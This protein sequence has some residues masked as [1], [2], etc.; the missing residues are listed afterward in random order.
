[1]HSVDPLLEMKTTFCYNF[2]I[3]KR[4]L[5]LDLDNTILQCLAASD[6]PLQLGKKYS[7]VYIFWM[8]STMFLVKFR[9]GLLWFL[10][11]LSKS[12]SIYLYTLASKPYTNNILA[13]LP[14][15]R[16]FFSGIFSRE[17]SPNIGYKTMQIIPCYTTINNITVIDDSLVWEDFTGTLL[18]IPKFMYF[19][20]G[21]LDNHLETILKQLLQ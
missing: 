17:D 7:D 5:V 15:L 2:P 14:A 4:L 20:N 3:E 6:L 12:F 11:T 21:E 10:E 16:N 8:N 1:V 9:P 18:R 19:Q 13:L